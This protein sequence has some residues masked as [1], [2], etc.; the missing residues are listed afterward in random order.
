MVAESESP[1]PS[2]PVEPSAAASP[3]TSVEAPADEDWATRF[4]YLLADFENY[5]KRV[6]RDTELARVRARTAI[7]RELLPLFEAT[8]RARATVERAAP[9]DSVRKGVELI[10]QEFEAFMEREG[11]EAVAELGGRFDPTRHEAVGEIPVREG[12]ADGTI[13]SVVQQG[14][15]MPGGLLRPAKVLVARTDPSGAPKAETGP[16]PDLRDGETEPTEDS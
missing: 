11:V 7:L 5:R 12:I 2:D 16:Q 3:K 13:G 15:R 10:A 1:G 14:Y 6:E 4:R 9:S 8:Q